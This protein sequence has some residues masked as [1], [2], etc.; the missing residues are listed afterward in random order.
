VRVLASLVIV[1]V[2]FIDQSSASL[3]F[4]ASKQKAL[5]EMKQRNAALMTEVKNNAPNLPNVSQ[6][7]TVETSVF[8]KFTAKA[9]ILMSRLATAEDEGAA[10]LMDSKAKYEFKLKAQH[11]QNLAVERQNEKIGQEITALY[12]VIADVRSGA[13]ELTKTSEGLTAELKALRQ[14]F[15]TAQEF[16]ENTINESATKLAY[17]S[18]ELQVLGELNQQDAAEKQAREHESYL[19]WV[20]TAANRLALLQTNRSKVVSTMDSLVQHHLGSRLGPKQEVSNVEQIVTELAATLRD[21]SIA[22]NASDAQLRDMFE[23]EY[24]KN[25][26]IH[27]ALLENQAELNATKASA[28]DL[29]GRVV[30]AKDHLQQ[31][32]TKLLSQ[33]EAVKHFSYQVGAGEKVAVLSRVADHYVNNTVAQTILEKSTKHFTSSLS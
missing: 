31:T 15:S 17:T 32:Y 8:R 27:E 4:L 19:R 33:T 20:A 25:E 24:K 11:E 16:V 18:P 29:Q 5:F 9:N 12:K 7:L 28:L 2:A 30:E 6:A 23:E 26:E 22:Q 21:L 14:N 10:A 1:A 13:S 3:G